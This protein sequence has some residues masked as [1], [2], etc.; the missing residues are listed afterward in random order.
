MNAVTIKNL[1]L[2][3]QPTAVPI[4][5]DANL[6]ITSGT[7]N[8]LIGPSGSGKS[9]LFKTLA[10]LYPEFGGLVT[11][12]ILLN[13]TPI[14]ALKTLERVQKI[15]LLFQNP[16]AQ[17]AMKTP[18]AELVF[19]LENLQIPANQ[20]QA[21]AEAALAF[22]DIS[23]LRDQNLQTLSGG[24]AQ[25]VALAI[26]LAMGSDIILLDEPF[27]SV[28]PQ[29]RLELLAKLKELQLQG[30]TIIISDHDLTGY[31]SLIDA[32]Y[33]IDAQ[34]LSPIT[35]FQTEFAK[36][37]KPTPSYQPVTTTPVFELSNFELQTGSKTLLT[38]TSLLIA[39]NKF[40]LIT[41]PN[42]VGK[43][44]LFMALIRLKNYAGRIT[45]LE[46]D[47][48]KIKVPKYAREVALVFQNA[49]Q[50]YLKMTVAEEIALSLKHARY[51]HLWHADKIEQTLTQLNM[52]HLKAHVIYQLSGGQQKKL[53]ILIMLILG[54]PVLLFDEPLAG[55]DIIS[56]TTILDLIQAS[57]MAQHQ[58]VLMIS[59]QLAGV[60]NYFNHHLIFNHQQLRYEV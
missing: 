31:E 37:T 4:I 1:T 60:T 59:H 35:N 3:Y 13:D 21:K 34:H 16:R 26:C 5:K 22:I 40:T 53:Q 11:G 25:K 14:T 36:F 30:H 19:T 12:D 38:D 51:P 48:K 24:E 45:Y 23:H 57:A 15:A 10:G 18:F 54:T 39:K 50:Q 55:L 33:R 42:G 20:I 27:A 58:T 28:D 41:G 52:A 6:T 17:F 29:A 46:Q 56:V 7:F 8:L 47:I 2:T 43:S 9:T 32:M 44:T 49:E